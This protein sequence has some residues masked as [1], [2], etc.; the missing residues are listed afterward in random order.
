MWYVSVCDGGTKS[1]VPNT[2]GR[3]GTAEEW[4]M[5]EEEGARCRWVGKVASSVAR[6][7]RT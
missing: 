5:E 4:G 2:E 6:I 1:M 3:R 7:R